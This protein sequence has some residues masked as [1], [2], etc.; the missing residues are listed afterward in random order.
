MRK[1]YILL[2]IAIWF[3]GSCSYA[4]PKTENKEL[5]EFVTDLSSANVKL[6]GKLLLFGTY[7]GDLSGL[8]YDHY[9]KLLKENESESDKGL[10]ELIKKS[11]KHLFVA[12]K[13]SFLIALY[14]KD[15]GVVL[16]D[17]ANSAFTDSIKQIGPNDKISNLVDFIGSSGFRP[18]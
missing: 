9:L 18:Q 7:K 13:N 8:T 15:F 2:I 5:E 3:L 4:Q 1:S 12:Q 14:S 17:M 6:R 10:S 11:D 16:Y